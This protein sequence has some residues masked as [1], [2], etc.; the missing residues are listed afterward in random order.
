LGLRSGRS[1]SRNS[2]SNPRVWAIAGDMTFVSAV[3]ARLVSGFLGA[4]GTDV[5]HLAAVEATTVLRPR[6][7]DNLSVFTFQS[8]ASAVASDVTSRAAVVA[9]LFATTAAATTAASSTRSTA[10]TECSV[11][12]SGNRCIGSWGRVNGCWGGVGHGNTGFEK[13]TKNAFYL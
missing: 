6:L 7:V 1:C 10:G 12:L 2:S 4:L 13:K 5:S 8:V 11:H 9:S 3:V